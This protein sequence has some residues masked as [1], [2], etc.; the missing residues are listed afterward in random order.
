MNTMDWLSP[1]NIGGLIIALGIGKLIHMAYAARIERQK[2]QKALDITNSGKHI[3]ADVNAFDA[4]SKRLELVEAKLDTVHSQLMDQKVE[5]AE[6]R[7]DAAHAEKELERQASEIVGLRKRNHDLS[8]EIQKR[9]AKLT[10][11]EARILHLEALLT[12]YQQG[13][14]VN[15]DEVINVKLVENPEEKE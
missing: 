2:V 3:D 1:Q 4:I 12:Q 14:P 15:T 11:L 8:D 6:L 13:H 7:S 9:D 5:N 10:L